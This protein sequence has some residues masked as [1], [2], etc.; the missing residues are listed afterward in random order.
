MSMARGCIP[1]NESGRCTKCNAAL[2]EQPEAGLCPDC[3]TGLAASASSA[4]T[5]PAVDA[6]PSGG[7]MTATLPDNGEVFGDYEI[8]EE[9]AHGGMGVVFKARQKSLNR[10]V[11][12]K[13]IR[14]ERLV[15]DEDVRRFHVEARAAAQLH[16][17]N[18][19]SIH[20]VGAVRGQNFYTMDFIAGSSLARLA[21]DR[22]LS[23]RNAARYVQK[24]AKAIHY[25]H[26]RQIVHR[27]LK[28]ANVL[29]DQNDEPQVTDFGLA[30]LLAGEAGTTVS[31]TI[32][33]SPSYMP[34]EQ[35]RG[36]IRRVGVQSDVYGL[37]AVLYDLLCGRP[38]FRAES[39]VETLRQVL[40]KDPA[41]PRLL[42]PK[43]PR[44][45]ETICLKCLEKTPER[46]YATALEV[47]EE[48][49]R[50][51]DGETILARP[52]AA[53]ARL[54]RWCRRK[55][56]LAA[57]SAL[58]LL[59]L[60]V[61]S[62]G[63]PIAVLKLNLSR[64]LAERGES[65]ARR[66]AYAAD[67]AVV[68]D[69]LAK[70]RSPYAQQLLTAHI[71]GPGQPDLRG[72]EW[73]FYWDQ[74]R[75]VEE[76]T[77]ARH[78]SSVQSL[79]VSLRGRWVASTDANGT[80][81]LWDTQRSAI[82]LTVANAG[83]RHVFSG[84]ERFL[85]VARGAKPIRVWSL[86]DLHESQ[87]RLDCGLNVQTLE[88]DAKLP[89]LF[90]A[91]GGRLN[92]VDLDTGRVIDQQTIPEGKDVAI[93]QDGR[94]VAVCVDHRN[95]QLWGRD[96]PAVRDLDTGHVFAGGHKVRFAFSAD[97][98]TLVS[99]AS[100]AT[101]GRFSVQV[102]DTTT[103]QQIQSYAAHQDHIIDVALSP[104]GRLIA[105]SGY[106]QAIEVREA[107]SGKQ[108]A[109]PIKTKEKSWALA[110]I[111]GNTRLLSGN[112]DGRV[113]LFPLITNL[114]RLALPE[115]PTS[116]L[117]D[118][119]SGCA[120]PDYSKLV[121]LNP[122]G[123]G[124]V[125]DT[126]ERRVT[127][128][129]TLPW[130]NIVKIA[131]TTNAQLLAC[132]LADGRLMLWD[133]A[134]KT[135]IAE[136]TLDERLPASRLAF[137]PNGRWLVSAAGSRPVQ[138]W[139]AEQRVEVPA[140]RQLVPKVSALRFSADSKVLACGHDG[141][142]ITLWNMVTASRITELPGHKF[143][144]NQLAFS[145]DGRRLASTGLDE[146]ARVWDLGSRQEIASFR[147]SRSSFFR[148]SFS[149]DGSRLLVNEWQDAFL[150]DIAA[151]RQVARLESF[152]PVFLDNDT[153]LGLNQTELRHWRAPSLESINA[154]LAEAKR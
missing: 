42:N 105:T 18:I 118:E 116:A 128:E 136:F 16:H 107:S 97:G 27:D 96:A 141:G 100:L 10:V 84:D 89:R 65:E 11:A 124:L 147:G 30:K 66:N 74:L 143:G 33:G 64:L 40:E 41:A 1:L 59:F 20:E 148:V 9:I 26:S 45:L 57:V 6:T 93:S 21:R 76:A 101:G 7:S 85:Y 35:A 113:R 135:G 127:T 3:R 109:L 80:L 150:F 8:I 98:R 121:L 53:P 119:K 28:P 52:V 95:I 123:A 149:P 78:G 132:A 106:D 19:V 82:V 88:C 70:G 71:P 49:G 139:D 114:N 115:G 75:S 51:Q 145:P 131:A 81:K 104:D 63:S 23:P 15:G 48:L 50:F 58:A 68:Q 92:T 73:R 5:K 55:P 120:S 87:D 61:I 14:G 43:V 142:K 34:P 110:L 62:V 140:W 36:D 117:L 146:R 44:D 4:E 151:Q 25:A 12:L 112:Q 144:L 13:M 77:L 154:E 17:P 99:T 134:R 137:A 152:L 102:W 83:Q 46:R 108:I 60:A 31:G 22:P 37:G 24:I 133:T 39:P 90:A 56:A 103:G 72:W 47:A 138:M 29:I 38:P 153:V 129:F 94:W 2:L 111:P 69:A 125:V 32:M 130:S 86:S 79:R 126:K 54:W 67:M 91:G 122:D